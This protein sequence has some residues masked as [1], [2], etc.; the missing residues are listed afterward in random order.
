MA[1]ETKKPETV[2]TPAIPTPVEPVYTV[3]EFATNAGHLFGS[4]ANSDIVYAAFLVAGITKATLS[5][6]KETVNRFMQKEVK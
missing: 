4:K 1:K 3:A 2:E 5:K 6:A